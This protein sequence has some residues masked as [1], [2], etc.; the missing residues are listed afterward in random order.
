MT[1]PA[2][3]T[4][5]DKVQAL[6]LDYAREM[7]ALEN[8]Y[9]EQERTDDEMFANNKQI[10]TSLNQATDRIITTVIRELEDRLPKK[11][12]Y[13][14]GVAHKYSDFH[15]GYNKALDQVQSILKEMGA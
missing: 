13:K 10:F 14:A 1:N 5:R 6:A 3:V 15:G 12:P 2:K 7:V 4:L 8:K 9:T 11:K